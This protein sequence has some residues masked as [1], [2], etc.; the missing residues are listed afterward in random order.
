MFNVLTH[1]E[2]K[3]WHKNGYLLLKSVITGTL[4]SQIQKAVDQAILNY[5]QNQNLEI[6]KGFGTSSFRI[7]NSITL[8][9]G[10]DVLLDYDNVFKKIVD[11]M[12]PYI[13]VMGTEIFV[14]NSST[15]YQKSF[16][17]DG[18]PGMQNFLPTRNNPPI[19]LKAQFFLTDVVHENNANFCFFPGSHTKK[20]MYKTDDC[21]LP[22]KY[23]FKPDGKLPKGA[24]QLIAKAGDVVLFPWSLW[25]GVSPNLGTEVRRS[26]IIR[27][28]QL[29]CR[30][31][32]HNIVADNIIQRFTNRQKRLLGDF[33]TD[34]N[35]NIYQG[36]V[37]KHNSFYHPKDQ[38]KI[39]VGN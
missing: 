38:I 8:T 6:N 14:R 23:N 2:R 10:I 18:G 19:M 37:Y 30:A 12:G 32:D 16:H 11:L 29:W 13:Q 21:S 24:V 4:L 36:N 31:R 27:Y 26:V 7:L 5:L 17:T 1:E 15:S 28:G 39:I 20:I 22:E 25:H 35:S 33:D 3:F 34:L 9:Q